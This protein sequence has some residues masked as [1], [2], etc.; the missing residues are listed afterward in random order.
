MGFLAATVVQ[1]F[2]SRTRL[3]GGWTST[4]DSLKWGHEGGDSGRCGARANQRQRWGHDSVIFIAGPWGDGAWFQAR[5]GTGKSSTRRKIRRFTPSVRISWYRF[6]LMI[7]STCA[8]DLWGFFKLGFQF[9]SFLFL[10]HST[11]AWF[12]P[13]SRARVLSSVN[14]RL[15]L[16]SPGSLIP[17]NPNTVRCQP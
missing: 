8:S 14:S 5:T 1:P 9:S 16:G 4:E 7:L 2:D 12:H 6:G 11:R 13:S 17:G 3:G 10:L 15:N